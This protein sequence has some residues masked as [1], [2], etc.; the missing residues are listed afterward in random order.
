MKSVEARFD[1]FQKKFPNASSFINFGRAIKGQ[2]F[3]RAAVAKHFRRLV[4]KSDYDRKDIMRLTNHFM[5]MTKSPTAFED[6]KI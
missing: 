3:T 1:R 4:D 6:A 2:K 5:K